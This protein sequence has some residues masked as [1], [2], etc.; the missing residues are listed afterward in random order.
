MTKENCAIL[1]ELREVGPNLS[2][3]DLS[4]MILFIY[5]VPLITIGWLQLK[6]IGCQQV[7]GLQLLS[8]S[9]HTAYNTDGETYTSG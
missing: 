4:Q 9:R 7:K 8:P 6:K 5:S 3:R 2:T 1:S